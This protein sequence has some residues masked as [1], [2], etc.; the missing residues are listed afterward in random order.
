ME[1][2]EFIKKPV[3]GKLTIDLP[4]GWEG[5]EVVVKVMERA[6][7]PREWARLPGA[8]RLAILKRFAGT[9]KFPDAP[10]D[11]YEVYEQ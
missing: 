1:A 5:K 4:K 10:I 8:D 7:D 11:K 9:T 6:Q 2:L 3:D